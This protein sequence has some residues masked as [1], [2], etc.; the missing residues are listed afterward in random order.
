MNGALTVGEN[1]G[2]LGGLSIAYILANSLFGG[3]A[4]FVVTFLVDRTNDDLT[5]AYYIM[6]SAVV[7]LVAA[8]IYRETAREPLRDV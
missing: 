7:S 4:P 8:L 2:D 1:I 3:T 6:A 5:A